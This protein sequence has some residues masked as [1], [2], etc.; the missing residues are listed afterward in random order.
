M[1]LNTIYKE[2]HKGLQTELNALNDFISQQRSLLHSME[3]RA[4]LLR[5][6]IKEVEFKSAIKNYTDLKEKHPDAIIIFRCG[7]FYE[8][9]M[10]DARALA[11][12]LGLT[13]TLSNKWGVITGFP[14]HAL[15]EYLP[16]IIRAGHRVAICDQL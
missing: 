5:K 15:D 2:Q 7:D 8:T 9:Y 1:E 14:H 16:K 10:D 6:Q 11:K 12:V 13:L 3:G 4:A